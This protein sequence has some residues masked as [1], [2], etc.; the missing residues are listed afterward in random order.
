MNIWDKPKSLPGCD[1]MFLCSDL[2]Y[3]AHTS[4]SYWN[5]YSKGKSENDTSEHYSE[6]YFM[7]KLILFFNSP[8][9]ITSQRHEFYGPTD[10]LANFGGLLGLFTGFSVLSLMEAIYFLTVRLCC[11]S[12][13]F[14]YWAGPDNS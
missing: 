8:Q 11:N 12:R 7:S 9:F 3:N 2:T 13:L 5:W 1:C 6:E 4:Q 14:G 10:F